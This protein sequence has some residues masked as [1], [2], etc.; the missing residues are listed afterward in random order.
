[1]AQETVNEQLSKYSEN[2][3]KVRLEKLNDIFTQHLGD[4]WR[5]I[6]FLIVLFLFGL[7]AL[8]AYDFQ[9]IYFLPYYRYVS[10]FLMVFIISITFFSIWRLILPEKFSVKFG[11]I[12]Y[13]EN[14]PYI[15][16]DNTKCGSTPVICSSQTDCDTTCVAKNGNDNYQCTPIGDREVY[17][18]GTQLSKNKSFCLPKE[19]AEKMQNCGTHTGRFV[20]SND[21][22]NQSW[23]C[24]CLY[25][26]MYG[27]DTCTD[28]LL[29]GTLCT[30][31]SVCWDPNNM[32]ISL[33]NT[34]PYDP[35]LQLKCNDNYT[36]YGGDCHEDKCYSGNTSQSVNAH[37]DVSNMACV[38]GE[39]VTQSN[40]SGYCYSYDNVSE[41]KPHPKTKKCQ[42]D[43]QITGPNGSPA[44]FKLDGICYLS[45]L[46]TPPTGLSY[47]VL[48]DV[49]SVTPAN[50]QQNL[51]EM[52]TTS[53]G[54]DAFYA[55]PKMKLLDFTKEEQTKMLSIIT[56]PTSFTSDNH[57]LSSM[58][59]NNL[60]NTNKNSTS[61]GVAKLCKS[62]FYDPHRDFPSKTFPLCSDLERGNM[63]SKT[64]TYYNQFC[65]A[66]LSD[67]CGI[68][69]LT[70]EACSFDL[71]SG[72]N[73][74]CPT[75]GNA[76]VI[77]KKCLACLPKGQ[78]ITTAGEQNQCCSGK[79]DPVYEQPAPGVSDIIIGYDCL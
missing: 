51:I 34:S 8:L 25:P 5:L 39:N 52:S 37:F 57:G 7:V 71:S 60:Y 79:S 70:N 33:I 21:N 44:L 17:Y 9:N 75:T 76:K 26:E 35:S 13:P 11:L 62:Y 38:C 32:P 48:V 19:G 41:C 77:N 18:L 28:P 63:L 68:D 42:Y 72:K 65:T 4:K 6:I 27:G 43:L 22:G 56:T 67:D 55:F 2:E 53:I 64:G 1:M 14:H 40:I 45:Y 36:F 47:N 73:C 59:S 20:W 66:N 31:Q 3:A 78:R 46:Y 49:T 23:T 29:N 50:I 24:K 30:N 54:T 15:P 16:P 58:F 10:I 69:F 61:F 12:P 74:N